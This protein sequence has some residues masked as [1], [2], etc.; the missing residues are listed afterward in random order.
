MHSL[1]WHYAWRDLWHHKTR[2]LLVI[3]SIAVGIFAFGSILGTIVTLNHDLPLQYRAIEPA[4]AILHVSPFDEN[5]AAAVR[6]MPAIAAAEGRFQLRV[7]YQQQ[8][9][10]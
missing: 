4:S 1:R 3:L 7:R 10:D 5:M 2:T 8:D 9:N 6:R